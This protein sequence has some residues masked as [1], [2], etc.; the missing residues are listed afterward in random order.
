[1]VV[2]GPV[3]PQAV[4]RS[5]QRPGKLTYVDAGDGYGEPILRGPVFPQMPRNISG[6]PVQALLTNRHPVLSNGVIRGNKTGIHGNS[7]PLS[8]RGEPDAATSP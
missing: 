1:M 8:P 4:G 2:M 5:T 6:L 3:T 7:T